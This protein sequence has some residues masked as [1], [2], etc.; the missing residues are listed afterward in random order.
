MTTP[1]EFFFSARHPNVAPSSQLPRQQFLPK[2]RRFLQEEL[3]RVEDALTRLSN[4]G[5]ADASREKTYL[6]Y[7][8]RPMR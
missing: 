7:D 8:V 2:E 5:A 1:I 6:V 3:Y 4:T